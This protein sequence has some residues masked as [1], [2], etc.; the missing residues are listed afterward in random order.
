LLPGVQLHFNFGKKYQKTSSK[1]L[2]HIFDFYAGEEIPLSAVQKG[3][4]SGT[5]IRENFL[6]LKMWQS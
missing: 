6:L 5:K 1:I 2:L 3:V 4:K